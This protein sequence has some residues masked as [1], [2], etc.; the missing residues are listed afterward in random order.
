VSSIVWL[1]A[2]ADAAIRAEAALHPDEETGGI[3]LGYTGT[4]GTVVAAA[5]GPGPEAKR[6]ASSF[7]PD[8]AWQQVE[9]ARRYE[10]SGRTH[11]YLGDWHTHPTGPAVPSRRDQRTLRRIARHR[12]ARQQRPLMAI[13]AVGREGTLCFWLA[14]AGRRRR[15]RQVVV[16]L[17]D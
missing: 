9:L 2:A 15:A 11:T 17:G 10:A 5:I 16:H 6:T 7:V 12:P 1:E 14:A 13:L 4:G 8:A 3:L